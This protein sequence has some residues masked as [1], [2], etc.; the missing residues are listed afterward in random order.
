MPGSGLRVPRV[1]DFHALR[2]QALASALAAAREDGAAVLGL[3]AGAET[4]LPLARA[5]RGLVGAFHRT[6]GWKAFGKKERQDSGSSKGVND[7]SPESLAALPPEQQPQKSS[8]GK[9]SAGAL[10]D[11][12]EIHRRNDE[13][14][15]IE[16]AD[17]R[18]H[19]ARRGAADARAAPVLLRPFRDQHVF[20][21]ELA[22]ARR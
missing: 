1:V 3:H 7:G 2:Q 15:L 22:A 21:I 13:Q 20:N 19:V 4:E 5:L 11:D 14:P 12:D 18:D 17:A 9:L 8:V 16:R 10:A 6:S